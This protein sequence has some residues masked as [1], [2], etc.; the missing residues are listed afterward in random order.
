LVRNN[1]SSTAIEARTSSRGTYFS[2]KTSSPHSAPRPT[3][4]PFNSSSSPHFFQ[5]P[6]LRLPPRVQE[7]PCGP[8]FQSN[9]FR[10]YTLF[11]IDLLFHH[12]SLFRANATYSTSSSVERIHPPSLDNMTEVSSTRLYLGNLPRDGTSKHPHSLRQE[13]HILDSNEP[14]LLALSPILTMLMSL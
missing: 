12:T 4:R 3:L 5:P 11:C 14:R 7:E 6:T 1:A 8:P 2:S 13:F 9:S 10:S